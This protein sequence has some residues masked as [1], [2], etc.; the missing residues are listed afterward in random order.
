LEEVPLSIQDDERTIDDVDNQVAESE[1]VKLPP[2]PEDLSIPLEVAE[3]DAIE[4]ALEVEG[5][6]VYPRQD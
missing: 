2:I 1:E 5:D 6:E 3:A 4:Q